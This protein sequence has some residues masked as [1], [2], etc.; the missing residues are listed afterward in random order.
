MVLASFSLAITLNTSPAATQS[1]KPSTSI[2]VEGPA[3]F[4]SCPEL[5]VSDLMGPF[6]SP[7]TII[8]PVLRIPF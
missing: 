5:S 7:A 2:G 1:S 8:S 3:S 6:F 4:I